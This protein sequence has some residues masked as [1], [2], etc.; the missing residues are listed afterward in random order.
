MRRTPSPH[1]IAL[2]FLTLLLPAAPAA[3]AAAEITVGESLDWLVLSRPHV[4]VAAVAGSDVEVDAGDGWAYL[5]I[6]YRVKQAVKGEP[7]AESSLRRPA[8]APKD[9]EAIR[10]GA[11]GEGAEFLL[12][13]DD[14]KRINYAIN[15][16]RPGDRWHTAAFATDFRVLKDRKA[17]MAVVEKRVAQLKVDPPK[18]PLPA[19]AANIFTP[20]DRFLRLDVPFDTPAHAALFAG[21]SAYLIVP[22][23]PEFKAKLLE[24]I[25]DPS[26]RERARAAA[27][28]GAYRGEET[29][30]ALKSLLND[31]ERTQIVTTVML[32]TGEKRD[33]K[34]TV[35]PVRQAAYDTLRRLGADVPKPQGYSDEYRVPAGL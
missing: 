5:T 7:P 12:F 2:A 35:Y 26:P 11:P 24:Q 27:L 25:R 13:F 10:Q 34:V 4:A 29:V 17:I 6:R 30:G 9:A 19:N 14:Q 18:E 23:D 15:L 33:R 20:P 31:P 28:L 32:A 16:D 1:V 8:G 22:A 3:P 21:S